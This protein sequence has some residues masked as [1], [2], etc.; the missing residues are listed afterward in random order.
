MKFAGFCGGLA[1][2]E[3]TLG[4]LS[5]SLILSGLVMALFPWST[6]RLAPAYVAAPSTNTLHIP[7]SYLLFSP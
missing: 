2:Y 7:I 1:V 6:I 5:L 3:S 4:Q